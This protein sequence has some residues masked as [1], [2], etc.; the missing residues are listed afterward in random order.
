MYSLAAVGGGKAT[1]EAC[2]YKE[3]RTVQAISHFQSVQLDIWFTYQD[4]DFRQRWDGLHFNTKTPF[5]LQRTPKRIPQT[6]L[7]SGC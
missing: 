4:P 7:G 1:D 3:M 6:W 2:L 5:G